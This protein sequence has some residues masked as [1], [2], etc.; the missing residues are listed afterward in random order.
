MV[1]EYYPTFVDVEPGKKVVGYT[2]W[3]TDKIP[4]HW[5][6]L[7]NAVDHLMV[8][9][10]WNRQVFREGGIHGPI[11]VVPHILPEFS[12]EGPD[13]GES[14]IPG[15]SDDDFVFYSIGTW[16][17]RKVQGEDGIYDGRYTAL[18]F[19]GGKA[20]IAYQYSYYDPIATNSKV[21][22]RIA[23]EM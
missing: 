10:D 7:L 2:V 11:D 12:D 19:A 21:A 13:D 20:I 6:P 9:C 14:L 4:A 15:V 17:T 23:K 3:E 1:P 18:T 22:L 8:P 5:S 16:T